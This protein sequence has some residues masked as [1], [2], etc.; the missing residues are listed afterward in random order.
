MY[1]LLLSDLERWRRSVQADEQD[2]PGFCAQIQRKRPS[3]SLD[4]EYWRIP[5]GGQ[6]LRSAR[7][8]DFPDSRSLRGQVEF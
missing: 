2:L 3:V 7:R 1:Q 5:E 4:G 8:G 6:G